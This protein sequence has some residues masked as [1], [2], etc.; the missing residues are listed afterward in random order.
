MAYASGKHAY[1]ISDRSGRRYRLR[2]MRTEWTG[3]K[4]GPDEF[5]PK[6]P[7]LFPPRA[8]PDPQ[9]LRDPRPESELTEQRSI[10]HGYNPVGF[11]DIPGITPPNNLV[12]EGEVGTVTVTISDTGNETVNVTGLAATSAVG[13]V[14][15]VDDAATF[16]STSITLDSTSQTFDEG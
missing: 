2:D 12:A 1:G 4:V 15:V 7:Q 8:F 14:T 9:A 10:Q 3:A 13:S 16:D 5:E 11:Q 6:H